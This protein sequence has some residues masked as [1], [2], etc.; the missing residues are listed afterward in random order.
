MNNDETKA[1]F[2]NV[3]EAHEVS[4][5]SEQIDAFN[6]GSN[7]EIDLLDVIVA[8]N[9]ASAEQVDEI[10]KGFSSLKKAILDAGK[11]R[12][13]NGVKVAGDTRKTGVKND[14]VNNTNT[15]TNIINTRKSSDKV[16]ENTQ[17]N[18]IEKITAN[19]NV[20]NTH[21]SSH[22]TANNSRVSSEPIYTGIDALQYNGENT[23]ESSDKVATYSPLNAT[24]KNNKKS[25]RTVEAQLV[26][27]G[28]YQSEIVP[29]AIQNES[30]PLAKKPTNKKINKPLVES[31]FDGFYEDGNGRL[32]QANGK[33]AS[34]AQSNAYKK[35]KGNSAD[36]DGT[37]KE[38]S[39]QPNEGKFSLG[40]LASDL[41]NSNE[42]ATDSL[43]AAV[44]GSYYLAAKELVQV[45][46]DGA[47]FVKRQSENLADFRERLNQKRADKKVAQADLIKAENDAGEAS[48]LAI[49][50]Q[51]D[52]LI[53]S[54]Q[55][56]QL[57]PKTSKKTQAKDLSINNPNTRLNRQGVNLEKAQLD[58]SK[59][60]IQ[61]DEQQ[62]A[63]L[64]LQLGD[65]EE[66]IS[67]IPV[68][69]DSDSLLDGLPSFE[70]SAKKRKRKTSKKNRLN[71]SSVGAEINSPNKANKGRVIKSE[72]GAAYPQKT[73]AAIDSV[74]KVGGVKAS[75]GGKF[76]SVL[77][78]GGSILSKAALPLTVAM[79]AYDA[80]SGFND[81][82]LHQEAFGLEEGQQATVGQKAASS[83]G[84]LLSLGGL[85]EFVGISSADIA[86]TIYSPFASKNDS[87]SKAIAEAEQ[88]PVLQQSNPRNSLWP[89]LEE[90]KPSS[91]SN[92]NDSKTQLGKE[93]TQIG[94]MA[95]MWDLTSDAHPAKVGINTFNSNVVPS[96][97]AGAVS[98]SLAASQSPLLTS[99]IEQIESVNNL[100]SQSAKNRKS[101][102]NKT[103]TNNVSKNAIASDP[104]V[105][106]VLKSIDSKISKPTNKK[107]VISSNAMPKIPY[108]FADIN[109]R[110]EANNLG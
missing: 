14:L 35:S 44:G 103:T 109:H 43:G 82:S 7:D 96:V 50:G 20:T 17:E 19:Q 18:S 21:K 74:S 32:R 16:A 62:H 61:K 105:L 24:S 108:D 49:Q 31:N 66:S 87:D 102:T 3:A 29:E 83:L 47:G 73:G 90:S 1:D 48:D 28:I 69:A 65:I 75:A 23:L 60:A 42:D 39:Y 91:I 5:S 26:D 101:I 58:T 9:D 59:K 99:D 86:K 94:E 12:L 51:G 27:D 22:I 85:T 6:L 79:S 30:V 25:N 10:E 80:V 38:K 40:Q 97:A 81:E 92:F 2:I 88:L 95:E 33:F 107:T 68:G 78:A 55:N 77:K 57:K 100:S 84:S 8:I 64:I 76:G 54:Q 4:I 36:K 98:A 46:S 71:S 110:I 45:A 63:E 89:E 53:P 104:D 52:K 37:K 93:K 41:T 13:V 70:K 67:N 11:F 72:R 56:K 15:N 106:K 34:K